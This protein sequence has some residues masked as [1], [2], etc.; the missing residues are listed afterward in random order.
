MPWLPTALS[1]VVVVLGAASE[2]SPCPLRRSFGLPILTCY[3]L[4]EKFNAHP[5][6][7]S[8]ASVKDALLVRLKV[9]VKHSNRYVSISL[10]LPARRRRRRQQLDSLLDLD[11]D[12]KVCINPFP[13]L[14]PLWWR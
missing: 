8:L 13:Y 4:G 14:L 12:Y 9:G 1:L 3:I 5:S 11:L 2:T 7:H 6:K 10:I